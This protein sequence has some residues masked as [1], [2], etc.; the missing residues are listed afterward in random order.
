MMR[1]SHMQRS[2]ESKHPLMQRLPEMVKNTTK[3]RYYLIFVDVFSH[4]CW[5]FFI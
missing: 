1:S 4:K 2:R 3:H 5:S